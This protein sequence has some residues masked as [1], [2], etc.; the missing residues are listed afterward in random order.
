MSS[1]RPADNP[2]I[3]LV[4]EIQ[5]PTQETPDIFESIRPTLE[6]TTRFIAGESLGPYAQR[7]ASAE[8]GEVFPYL[9]TE[10][11]IDTPLANLINYSA[12]LVL[13]RRTGIKPEAETE[14]PEPETETP[15]E[16]EEETFVRDLV[17][18]NLG[19]EAENP[20]ISSL[21]IRILG[22]SEAMETLGR[23]GKEVIPHL[24]E[25]AGRHAGQK[26]QLIKA[27][28]KPTG[29]LKNGFPEETETASLQVL[30]AYDRL[31]SARRGEPSPVDGLRIE[32]ESGQMDSLIARELLTK[33]SQQTES[34]TAQDA[35]IQ[36]LLALQLRTSTT[37][38][39]DEAITRLVEQESIHLW[40]EESRKI[41]D[42][43]KQQ[44]ITR[45]K[46]NQDKCE[47]FLAETRCAPTFAT[48]DMIA[49]AASRFMVGLAG[50][51]RETPGVSPMGRVAAFVAS[52]KR[53]AQKPRAEEEETQ[54][55]PEPEKEPE[56][57]KVVY[58]NGQGEEFPQD[59]ERYQKV[60][61]DYLDGHRGEPG[62]EELLE[63]VIERIS[64]A[65][66]SH[67]MPRG[68]KKLTMPERNKPW[69][70]KKVYEIRV[71]SSIGLPSSAEHG[72]KLRVLFTMRKDTVGIVGICD[73]DNLT[74]QLRSLG[75]AG[76]PH[77]K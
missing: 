67:G 11:R 26:F 77:K 38:D 5:P 42:V 20:M 6:E 57:R 51:T 56:P 24:T 31:Q 75:I 2:V 10:R 21:P 37:G 19:K 59:S 9:P 4:G 61:S 50:I 34:E 36:R 63:S 72:H 7:V 43:K 44:Y 41:L 76:R 70:L 39:L 48:P 66:L 22:V 46:R 69:H 62:L 23:T 71:T 13:Q 18:K 1:S 65:D 54:P 30:F 73:K 52:S 45:Y 29:W 16:V 33:A 49:K 15:E 58:I 47:E 53:K 28:A 40:P 64:T 8:N 35:E 74:S 25:K 27:L 17:R 60:V 32:L 68:I 55:A 14:L 3:H 12:N